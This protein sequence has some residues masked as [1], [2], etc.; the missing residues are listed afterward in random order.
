MGFEVRHTLRAR[1]AAD[2]VRKKR[3]EVVGKRSG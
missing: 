3:F 1:D 2:V